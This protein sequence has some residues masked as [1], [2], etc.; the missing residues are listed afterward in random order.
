MGRAMA[1]YLAQRGCDLALHYAS[2]ADE[3]EAVADGI[4]AM[5]RRAVTLQADLLVESQVQGLI[6]RAVAG[7]GGAGV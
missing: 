7:L 4:R 1:L 2:S 5:G 6:A 3:A